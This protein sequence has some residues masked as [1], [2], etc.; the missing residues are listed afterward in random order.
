MTMQHLS[1][2]GLTDRVAATAAFALLARQCDEAGTARNIGP[3]GLSEAVQPIVVASLASRGES[4]SAPIVWIVPDP[5]LARMHAEALEGFLGDRRPVVVFPSPDALPYERGAWDPTSRELRMATLAA[6]YEQR[7]SSDGGRAPVIVTT[8][9]GLITCTCPLAAMDN[10]TVTVRRGKQMGQTQL[11]RALQTLGYEMVEQVDEPGHVARRGGIVDVF[12]PS[13]QFPVRLEWFGDEIDTLQTFEVATQRSRDSLDRLVVLPAAEVLP[14]L[15]PEAASAL[16]GLRLDRLHPLAA[17][18]HER[19]AERLAAGERFAGIEIYMPWLHPERSTL[20][21]HL[22]ATSLLIFDELERITRSAEG[23]HAQAETVRSELEEARELPTDWPDAALMDSAELE[24]AVERFRRLDVGRAGYVKQPTDVASLFGVPDRYGGQIDDAVLELSQKVAAGRATVVV[25]RQAPRLAE[26]FADGG[27]NLTSVSSLVSVPEPGEISVVHGALGAGWTLDDGDLG[28]GLD[29]VTDGELFGWRMPFRRRRARDVESSVRTDYFAEYAPGDHVVHIEHGIAEFRGLERMEVGDVERDYLRLEYKSGDVLFVPTHQADRVARYVGTGEVAPA[30]TRL[31]TADWEKAKARAK[32]EVEDIAQELLD[33]YARRE[34]TRRGA[35]APD[36]PWQAEMEA[37]FPYIETD[38]QMRAIDDVKSDMEAE[39]PMDRLVVGDVGFGKTEVALRAAFKA[40]MGGKQVAILAP[41]TILAQQHY[42][43]FSARLAAF[44]V[45]VDVL[46]RFRTKAQRDAIVTKMRQGEVDVVI[47]THRLLQA[48][49]RFKDLGLLIIDEEQRFG[50]KHK[51]RLRAMAEGVDTLTLTATPIPRTMHLA[52]TGLRDLTKIDTPPSERLPVQTQLGP[53]DDQLV[54]QAIR[55]EIARSGQVFYVYNRVRGIELV[56]QKVNKL[57]PE[58]RTAVA[59]GQMTEGAL[60][61]AMLDFVG[62]NIDVLVC[63]S[64]VESGLDIPNA[65]TLIVERAD[66]FGLA[67]LHQLRGRVGRSAQRA[68][69]YFLY[70]PGYDL[71]QDAHARLEALADHS[72]LGSG[73][74]IAMRDLEIRGAGEILGSR[75]HGQVAAIGLDLYTR[76]L[77]E[78]DQTCEG[79]CVGENRPFRRTSLESSKTS[80]L[81]RCPPSTFHSTPSCRKSTSVK[82]VNARA[83]IDVW[84]LL[85]IRVRWTKS[86]TSSGIALGHRPQKRSICSRY[87]D[88]V[89]SRTLAV[90][91]GLLSRAMSWRFDGQRIARWIALV[92]NASFR[93]TL[94]LG[95]NVS[96]SRSADRRNDGCS[97]SRTGST[98][99]SRRMKKSQHDPWSACVF[100]AHSSCR[101]GVTLMR[102]APLNERCD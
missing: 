16:L 80:I 47:G 6:L 14:K 33:L 71:S 39:R 84:R 40:V 26:L 35:F 2:T 21:E 55:R 30:V 23:V 68:H 95:A 81:V 91:P 63:T 70:P 52:L 29:V 20:F 31:G 85:V 5:A 74:R 92:S 1:L 65:N 36:T 4:S 43:T 97:T 19:H 51:E 98:V 60:A 8:V 54:R 17:S 28:R 89:C 78:S 9:R 62:G 27:H 94:E 58:A 83:S 53:Y 77:A 87:S 101:H 56:A 46:S 37:A 86:R 57:V 59:H 32:K 67:Q 25:S 69:A 73:F 100:M 99:W 76:L 7:T 88:Y 38:D 72:D 44:P 10:S 61:R 15:G 22:P 93:V 66:R 90:R 41:T 11:L 49:I 64:I 79:R 3:L 102:Q 18:E 42:E 45:Q 12:V 75:Q 24:R 13:H 50:V 34:T 82:R 96:R 48:D